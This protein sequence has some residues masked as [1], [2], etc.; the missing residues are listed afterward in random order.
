MRSDT[1]RGNLKTGRKMLKTRLIYIFSLLLVSTV[2]LAQQYKVCKVS[3]AP[4][5]VK[6]ANKEV[7]L[8]NTIL[9]G[10]EILHFSKSSN[11]FLMDTKSK[12]IFY[13]QRY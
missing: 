2:A 12:D 6:R 5:A 1:L 11:I 9:E 4:A 7:V 8:R 13:Y 10:K 3:S